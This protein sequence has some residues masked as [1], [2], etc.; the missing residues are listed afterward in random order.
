MGMETTTGT[1]V[2]YMG[3]A[4]SLARK[5]VGSVSPNPPVG[6]VLVR[7]GEVVGEGYTRPPGQAHAEIVAIR[8]AG[9]GRAARLSTRRLSRATTRAGR[10]R[11]QR[12]S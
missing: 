9:P 1:D 4:L 8:Q 2:A 7:D 10:G 5:A 3:L 6:A 12:R 11:A